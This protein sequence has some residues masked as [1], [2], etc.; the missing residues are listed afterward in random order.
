MNLCSQ[1]IILQ[2]EQDYESIKL[3]KIEVLVLV[4]QGRN[5]VSDF[6]ISSF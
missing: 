5:G 6:S 3:V 1:T 4:L 2:F